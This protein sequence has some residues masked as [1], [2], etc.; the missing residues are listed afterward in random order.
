[1]T[2][3]KEDTVTAK[4]S[5]PASIPPRRRDIQ[6]LRAIAVV[7]VVAFHANLPFP[8]GYVGVDVFFVISGFV[9]TAMLLR[10]RQTTGTIR[11]TTFY[12]RRF[13]RLTPAL[14]LMVSSTVV[15][16]AF[17][18]SP[19]WSQQ[20][21]TS[22]AVGAM[23]LFANFAIA[24]FSGGYFGIV[25]ET[26]PLLHTWSLSVEEQFYLAFPILLLLGWRVA[27]RIGRPSVVIAVLVAALGA[28]SFAISIGVALGVSFPYVP[29]ALLGFYSPVG[30][31][32]EFA[33]G[34]LLAA[35]ATRIWLPTKTVGTVTGIT[36]IALIAVSVLAFTD[37]TVFPGP[38]TVVPVLGT[39]L[40]LYAGLGSVNPIS[41]LLG[42]RPL[43]AI[44][45]ISYSWYLWHWPMIVFAELIW[46]G[47][48]WGPILAATVSLGPAVASYHFVERPLRKPVR[49]SKRRLTALVAVTLIVPLTL[50]ATLDLAVK[51]NYWSARMALMQETQAFHP[52]LASGC[53]TPVPITVAT[54]ANC[55]WNASASGEPIYL[56]G[57][58]VVEQYG[59]ALIGASLELNRPLFMTT[60][61]GCPPYRIT[62]RVPGEPKPMDATEKAGCAPYIDGTLSWLEARTPGLVIM[63]ANDVSW[64][65]PSDL[66]DSI[67]MTGDLGDADAL[68]KVS[69]AP[70]AE[71]KRALVSGMESTAERLSA[72]GHEVVIA[73]APP[74]YR[75]PTPSWKPGNCAVA[76]I[77]ADLCNTSATVD[78]MDL[79]QGATREAVDEAARRTGSAIL[80]LRDY[81]CPGSICTTRHGDLG[82]YRDDIHI[83]VPA[84]KDL[85]PRFTQ[86][87]TDLG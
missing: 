76:V 14:A 17:L 64:W 86:F 56:I 55:E 46:P 66:V 35:I 33:A 23:L 84:S 63:G 15:V 79:V 24:Q 43:V 70:N 42:A 65:S 50:A 81:F 73:K 39:V 41:R 16:S 58:S 71:K 25:A 51:S 36:G 2:D 60:A 3:L 78:E 13:R 5:S 72:A 85:I 4:H 49:S 77:M 8:G 48:L 6:G 28:V 27:R 61:P 69:A 83:S 30:R 31:V 80:D 82:L 74:S 68:A 37:S 53:I 32:W 47:E 21:V 62:L 75:F 20:L 59:E 7:A 19:L 9:I 45:N 38:A 44:G 29:S 67:A 57:D 54:Q 18:M 11:L 40:V 22:T 10:E 34:A 52:G 26:N 12:V 87:L 1:M